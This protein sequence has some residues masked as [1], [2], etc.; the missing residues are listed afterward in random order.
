MTMMY[1][2]KASK[3]SKAPSQSNYTSWDHQ[4]VDE[5]PDR[6]D[7]NILPYLAKALQFITLEICRFQGQCIP[8]LIPNPTSP[9][10]RVDLE[11]APNL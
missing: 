9:I 7:S 4:V 3:A 11:S 1:Y 8:C 10:S 6:S 5:N 2:A